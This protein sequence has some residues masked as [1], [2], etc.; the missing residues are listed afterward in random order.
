M[1]CTLASLLHD[2]D[3]RV[4]VKYGEFAEYAA[5]IALAITAAVL[6][7]PALDRFL[8]LPFATVASAL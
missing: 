8:A 2:E 4:R 3:G 7:A 1:L 6:A 5:L